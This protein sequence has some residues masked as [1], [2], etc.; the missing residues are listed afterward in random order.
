MYVDKRLQGV[1]AVQALSRLNRCNVKMQKQDTF[2][3]DFYNTVDE[4]KDAFDPFYTATSLTEATDV[5]VLHDLK[6]ALDD[7][8]LYNDDDIERFNRLFFDGAD[9]ELLHPIIDETVSRFDLLED[10]EDKIDFKIKAKQ[11]VKLYAQ[12]ASI[13]PFEKLSWEKLYWFIKFLVPKL[14][15]K[16]N[17]T[18]PV[19]ELLESI[20][21]STYGLERVQLNQQIEL[22]AE[23]SEL[24]PENP[25]V[26]GF[27]GGE[28]ELSPLDQII[29]NFN[30][31][32]FSAWD[33]TPE[34]QKV[35]LVNILEHVQNNPAYQDQVLN[36][37]DEQNRRI[38]LSSLINQA[39]NKERR[40]ELELYKLYAGDN[41]FKKAFDESIIR[42][43]A[44]QTLDESA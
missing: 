33:A 41:D 3:L 44:L 34:E 20:D 15:V 24:E 2:I 13:I 39:V 35:K 25:N 7:A 8:D 10:D 5:N 17:E 42:I 23:D 28:E 36:N 30:E 31:R 38:A 18:D 9:A 27:H 22:E 16:T 4:I 26:R 40:R 29:Q 32:F 14:Q 12:L 19:D 37:P 43:L 21:L 11:F 6:D 1:L